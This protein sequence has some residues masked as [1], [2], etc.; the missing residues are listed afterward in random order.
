MYSD[1]IQLE[2]VKE[3]FWYEFHVMKSNGYISIGC[4]TRIP[5]G[6]Y[7]LLPNLGLSVVYVLLLYSNL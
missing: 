4:Q 5:I 2:D 7:S 1:D 3:C 6:A